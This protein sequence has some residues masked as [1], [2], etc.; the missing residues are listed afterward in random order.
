LW[1]FDLNDTNTYISTD[2]TASETD[3]ESGTAIDGFIDRVFFADNKGRIWKLDPANYDAINHTIAPVGSN[4]DVG[5]GMPALFST[6]VTTNGLGQDRAIA[7]T[8]TAATDASNRLALY[9][10]TGGTEDTPANVQNAFYAVYADTG[11]IRSALDQNSGIAI[12]VKFYGGVVFNNGQLVFTSGQD[13]SGLGLC[14]PTAGSVTAIDANTFALQFEA[15]AQSKIVAPL[16]AQQGEIYTVTITGKLMA[17]QFVGSQG[18]TAP[19]GGGGSGGPTMGSPPPGGGGD[20]SGT[21][22]G[23]TSTGTL[24]NPFKILGWRQIQ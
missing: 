6:R 24:T 11:E 18:G 13:L 5:L 23:G 15:V 8:L 2:I 3:D 9:F 1:R 14:A 21:G 17:S 10:G 16:Y 4:V 19:G 7:G 22:G 12:G 20:I